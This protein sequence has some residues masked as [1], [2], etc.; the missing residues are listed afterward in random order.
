MKKIV[1]LVL[2]ASLAFADVQPNQKDIEVVESLLIEIK[3]ANR[4]ELPFFRNPFFYPPRLDEGGA[5]VVAVAAPKEPKLQS[6]I[7]ARA[8]INGEWK[9][10]GE[11]TVGGWRIQRVLVDSVILINGKAR[12]ALSLNDG[13]QKNK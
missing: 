13:A 2:G 12:K 11:T 7:G 10:A 6:V 4:P 1:L 8:L 9:K 3:E 5:P